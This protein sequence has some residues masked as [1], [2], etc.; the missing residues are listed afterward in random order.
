MIKLIEYTKIVD[1]IIA[2]FRCDKILSIYDWQFAADIF[3]TF[4]YSDTFYK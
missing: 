2:L 1:A 3:T 4:V